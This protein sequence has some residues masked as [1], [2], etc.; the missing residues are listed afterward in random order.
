MAEAG[1]EIVVS[2]VLPYLTEKLPEIITTLINLSDII[3]P[4]PTDD[5]TILSKQ[6]EVLTAL[7]TLIEQQNTLLTL[8]S[9]VFF[10]LVAFFVF[11]ILYKIISVIN[12]S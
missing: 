5:V 4:D 9:Y 1:T 3:D 2:E 10:I 7:N 6:D 12:G 8:M 11:K